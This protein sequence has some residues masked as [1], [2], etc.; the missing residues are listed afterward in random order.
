VSG[1]AGRRI[2]GRLAALLLVLAA[3]AFIVSSEAGSAWL[4]LLLQQTTSLIREHPVL[5]A[6]LFVGVSALSAMLM[7][8]SG[9]VLVP[10]GIE[11]WGGIGCLLLL[12]AGWFLGGLVSYGIGRQFGRSIVT[13]LVSEQDLRGYEERMTGNTG[14]V[15]A[16]LLQLAFPSD[17]VGYVFGLVRFPFRV[18]LAAL[19]CAELPY[20]V[21]TVFLGAAFLQQHWI[22]LAAGLCGAAG[23]IAWQWRMRRLRS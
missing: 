11:S 23:V 21:G 8:F 1:S 7:F 19:L 5:G 18:Y 14:F 3:I 20:A 2:A 13:H 12:W 15:A 6:A 22:A 16:L 4:Q 17:V 9:A 10:V